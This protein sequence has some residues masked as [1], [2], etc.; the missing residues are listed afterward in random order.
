M[1]IGLLKPLQ[2]VA[3]PFVGTSANYIGGNINSSYLTHPDY[4]PDRNQLVRAQ[5]VLEQD[6]GRLFDYVEPADKNRHAYSHRIF[7]QLGRAS[8]EVE[9][10]LSTSLRAAGENKSR[11]NMTDYRRLNGPLRLC[12]YRVRLPIW[13]GGQKEFSPF[14]SWSNGKNPEWWDSYNH[15][16]HDRLEKFDE[17]NLLAATRATGA[18]L[19]CLFSQLAGLAMES[20][21]DAFSCYITTADDWIVGDRLFALQP[22]S[23]PEIEKYEFTKEQDHSKPLAQDVPTLT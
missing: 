2:R 20:S 15:S 4:A 23:W 8:M 14:E 3:R 6:L 18:A 9:A 11:P 13:E 19:V 5:G 1:T 7:S 10:L 17:A 22:P 16:K 21:T 12:E